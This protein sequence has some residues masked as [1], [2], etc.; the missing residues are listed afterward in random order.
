MGSLFRWF[1][2]FEEQTVF[3]PV[4]PWFLSIRRQRP[5]PDRLWKGLNGEQSVAEYE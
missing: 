4:I 5:V 3:P 2:E 1:K